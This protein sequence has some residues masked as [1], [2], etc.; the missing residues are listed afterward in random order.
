M[1][2]H[3]THLEGLLWLLYGCEGVGIGTG[4]TSAVA[5]ESTLGGG[6]LGGKG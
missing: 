5:K 3:L 1:R 4:V 6:Y 2:E